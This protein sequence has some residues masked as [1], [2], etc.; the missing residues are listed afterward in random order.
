MGKQEKR[1]EIREKREALPIDYREQASAG[2]AERLLMQPVFHQAERIFCYV[3]TE[4]EP[5][6]WKILNAA[7]RMGKQLSV[8]RCIPGRHEMEAVRIRSLTELEPGILG[9]LEPRQGLPVIDAYRL[10]LAIIPCISADRYGGRLGHGAGYYD[11]FL[12]GLRIQKYCLCFEALLSEQI[13]MYEN[14]VR[15]DHVLTEKRIYPAFFGKY[16]TKK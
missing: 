14:D 7:L 3:S 16:R 5:S 13:P 11:R 15:M 1:Q 9:I 2:I 12:R 10:E 6:T 8:P 4:E